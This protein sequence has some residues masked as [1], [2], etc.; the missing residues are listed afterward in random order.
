MKSKIVF[1]FSF[2]TLFRDCLGVLQCSVTDQISNEEKQCAFPFVLDS[3]PDFENIEC[4]NQI[5]PDGKYWCSTKV[6]ENGIH[7]EGHWGYCEGSCAIP[8]EI[9]QITQ[10]VN[11]IIRLLESKELENCPCENFRQCKWV[12]NWGK[13][14][15]KLNATSPLRIKALELARKQV[16][17][18]FDRKVRCCDLDI[19]N[20]DENEEILWQNNFSVQDTDSG[21]WIPSGNSYM[22][23]GKDECGVRTRSSNL[24]GGTATRLGDYPYMALLGYLDDDGEIYYKCGGSILNRKYILTAAHCH[25][26]DQP[27]REVVVGEHTIGRRKRNQPDPQTLA[28]EKIIQHPEWNLAEFYNGYDIALVRVKELIKL[29]LDDSRYVALPV[30]LP[31]NSDDHGFFT[32]PGQ[33]LTVTGWGTTSN[34]RGIVDENFEKYQAASGTMIR[35]Y[36]PIIDEATCKKSSGSA[37]YSIQICAGGER[38]RDACKGDSGGP[39]VFREYAEGPY[40]QVGIVSFGTKS[41]GIGKPTIATRVTAFLRWIHS[42]LEP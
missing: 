8:D 33:R 37:N 40:Y 23:S 25:S 41:C 2:I 26:F 19:P 13:L 31:W 6:D 24:V 18:A 30:C 27:I 28:I 14:T 42:N 35:D 38:G 4:T 15:N 7:Q 1:V 20:R 11:N 5:D 36:L 17:N 9:I 34:N 10:D 39:M 12:T 32:E 21:K 29:Y 22:I 16:C 3:H